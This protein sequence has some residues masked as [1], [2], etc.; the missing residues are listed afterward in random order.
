[1]FQVMIVY[2]RK[3]LFILEAEYEERREKI[4]ELIYLYVEDHLF[5]W[6]SCKFRELSTE[7]Q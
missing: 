1:M 5:N 7:K 2:M 3:A 6:C 4:S